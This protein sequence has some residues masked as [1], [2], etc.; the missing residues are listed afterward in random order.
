MIQSDRLGPFE[1]DRSSLLHFADGLLG[2]EDARDFAVAGADDDDAYFWLQSADDAAL[3]FLTV[4][5]GLFYPEYEPDLPELD[6]EALGL[7]Q[8]SDAHVLTIVTI[9]DEAITANLLGPVVINV[10]SRAARQVVL[11]EQKWSVR[12]PLGGSLC[13]S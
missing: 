5:P 1:C 9:T 4:V 12:A 3:A 13:S 2:F 11:G 6:V 8:P 10:K 7:T